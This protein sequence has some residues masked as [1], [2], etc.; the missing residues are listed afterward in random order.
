MSSAYCLCGGVLSISNG[1]KSFS[2]SA[3]YCSG[4]G[5]LLVTDGF[6]S[7]LFG[8]DG[9][10]KGLPGLLC[11]RLCIGLGLLCGGGIGV[12]GIHQ[13]LPCRGARLR[14][15]AVRRAAVGADT[16]PQ[17]CASDGLGTVTALKGH[18]AGAGLCGHA[19]RHGHIA[20]R[21]QRGCRVFAVRN[22]PESPD[23]QAFPLAGC[24]D[25]Q[26]VHALIL[27]VPEGQRKCVPGQAYAAAGCQRDGELDHN[28]TPP[29]CVLFRPCQAL[30]FS[31]SSAYCLSVSLLAA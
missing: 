27:S 30:V 13:L 23:S 6:Q 22:V 31:V 26:A 16:V 3:F 10:R 29:L 2:L 20:V 24:I 21:H 1:V 9:V 7:V 19:G 11:C 28:A 14:H 17:V 5:S 8:G 18:T 12:H 15:S 4:S 25:V